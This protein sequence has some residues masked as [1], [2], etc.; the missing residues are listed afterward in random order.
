M[1][2]EGGR[3]ASPAGHDDERGDVGRGSHAQHGSVVV[4]YAPVLPV[5]PWAPGRAHGDLY[6]VGGARGEHLAQ[7][8]VLTCVQRRRSSRRSSGVFRSFEHLLQWVGN[9]HVQSVSVLFFPPSKPDPPLMST[10]S[11]GERFL[12]ARAK[13][14]LYNFHRAEDRTRVLEVFK[15][16]RPRIITLGGVDEENHLLLLEAACFDASQKRD[17]WECVRL[18]L[19]DY[20]PD[21]AIGEDF[22][23]AVL[24]RREAQGAEVGKLRSLLSGLA[25]GVKADLDISTAFAISVAVNGGVRFAELLEEASPTFTSLRGYPAP[26]PERLH[27]L[28][29]VLTA[30]A[31]V[32]LYLSKAYPFPITLLRWLINACKSH[33]RLV[34]AIATGETAGESRVPPLKIPALVHFALM[35]LGL[36]EVQAAV[37]KKFVPNSF[38]EDFYSALTLQSQGIP[39]RLSELMKRLVHTGAVDGGGS[40][41]WTL[42]DSQGSAVASSQFLSTFHEPVDKLRE[43]SNATEQLIATFVDLAAL[44]R[45]EVPASIL[46]MHL[47]IKHRSVDRFLG[48]ILHMFGPDSDIHILDEVGYLPELPGVRMFRFTSRLARS[49]LVDS[50]TPEE[51]EAAAAALMSTLRSRIHNNITPTTARL[52]YSLSSHLPDEH[53]QDSFGEELSWWIGRAEAEDL[54]L[55]IQATVTDGLYTPRELFTVLRRVMYMWPAYRLDAVMTGLEDSGI[56]IPLPDIPEYHHL[57]ANICFALDQLDHGESHARA[58]FEATHASDEERMTFLALLHHASARR[59]DY[60]SALEHAE[61]AVKIARSSRSLSLAAAWAWGH[62]GGTLAELGRTSEAQAAA[63]E[64]VALA[65]RAFAPDSQERGRVYLDAARIY[66]VV[67]EPAVALP[68][69]TQA[70]AIRRAHFGVANVLE[71]STLLLLARVHAELGNWSE[72]ARASDAAVTTAVAL[73]GHDHSRTADALHTAGNVRVGMGNHYAAATLLQQALAIETKLFGAEDIRVAHTLHSLAVCYENVDPPKTEQYLEELVALLS[74]RGE[75]GWSRWAG[76]VFRLVTLIEEA[77]DLS[78]ALAR[79]ESLLAQIRGEADDGIDRNPEPLEQLAAA[80]RRRLDGTDRS[81]E[82][83]EPSKEPHDERAG[84][85]TRFWNIVLNRMR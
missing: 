56:A 26:G 69:V 46:C 16:P 71:S 84:L 60:Q 45:D 48:R 14:E 33:D 24:C 73:F 77:G 62:L 7:E 10:F 79:S 5:E 51:R 44:F 55:H 50:Y 47:G 82:K 22:L 8:A 38:T 54:R 29:N 34:L 64:L 43:S 74:R 21:S 32:V 76:D 81:D 85:W 63:R 31:G 4:E 20:N 75:L 13:Y 39:W 83:P 28:I 40:R 41:P 1:R 70:L 19:E 57:R 30:E 58:A 18:S 80:Y 9:V 52:F 59:H 15:A 42:A 67:G 23:N 35:P 2:T 25:L 6:R 36:D 65:E 72:A 3:D 53:H 68:Y 61:A 17:R 11:A 78:R 37:H 66:A 49:V 27:A 12:S